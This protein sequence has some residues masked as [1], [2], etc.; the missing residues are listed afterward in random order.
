MGQLETTKAAF[1]FTP[2]PKPIGYLD[3]EDELCAFGK[4]LFD[5]KHLKV[6]G[7]PSVPTTAE[8]SYR[9]M[10]SLSPELEGWDT[11]EQ[12][13]ETELRKY[14]DDKILL[15]ASK[16]KIEGTAKGNTVIFS[17]LSLLWNICQCKK[18]DYEVVASADG[19]DKISKSFSVFYIV[20]L[21]S[22][23]SQ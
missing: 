14:I 7:T 5:T 6:W 10:T 15:K 17:S 11:T 16:E 2:P 1:T 23:H 20:M 8:N 19:T 21:F 18:I 3:N 4:V 9:M 22:N 13:I 12:P